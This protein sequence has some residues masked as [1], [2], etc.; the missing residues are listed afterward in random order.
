MWLLLLDLTQKNIPWLLL[1]W[2]HFNYNRLFLLSAQ[3][4][5]FPPH[6]PPPPLPYA[7]LSQNIHSPKAQTPPSLSNFDI[8][9]LS[10][11]F[12]HSHFRSASFS[13]NLF[14]LSLYIS[15]SLFLSRTLFHALTQTQTLT[16]TFSLTFHTLISHSLSL[17]LS[18][19]PSFSYPLFFLFPSLY[20]P[21]LE[22]E[23]ILF[24]PTFSFQSQLTTTTR[25]Y[26]LEPLTIC[27]FRVGRKNHFD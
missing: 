8:L 2:T 13:L 6:Y 4:L 26:R 19:S 16:H 12:F 17:S 1:L 7:R 25:F 23:T 22:V 5:D 9:P 15:L 24:S 14:S 20:S 10:L 27:C 3:C 11:S 18:L 21:S